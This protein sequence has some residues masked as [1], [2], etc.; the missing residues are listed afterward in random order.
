MDWITGMQKALNYIEDNITENLD[1]EE[2]AKKAYVSSFHFQRVFSILCGYTLGEY[3]R[4]RRLTLAGSEISSSSAKI[5]DVA[6]KYGYDTPES[7]SRAFTRFHGVTPTQARSGG[8]NLKSFSR[9]SIKLLLEG[10]N[11]MNYRIEQKPE[12]SLIGFKTQFIG[13]AAE[14][15]QQERDFWVNTRAEQDALMTIRKGSNNIWYDVNTNF[16]DYGYDH[17]IAVESEKDTPDGYEQVRIQPHTYVICETNRVRYPTLL[18][19][20]LRK[21]IISEWLPSSGYVLSDAPEIAVTHWYQKP[22]DEKRYIEL[23]I[24]VEKR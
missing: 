14:R 11:V 22:D 3:I 13:D 7:F 16:S 9:L 4:N 8:A 6:L 15:F 21:Q 5:I 2:I 19:M 10:G 12:I 1:Y 23:W 20:D 17:Y 24:P 18:H